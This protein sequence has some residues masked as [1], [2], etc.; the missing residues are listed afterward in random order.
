M[1]FYSASCSAAAPAI[2]TLMNLPITPQTEDPDSTA[3]TQNMIL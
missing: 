2:P 3:L 1:L